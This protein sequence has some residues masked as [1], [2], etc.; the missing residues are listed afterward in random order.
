MIENLNEQAVK[1]I[2]NRYGCNGLYP[3]AYS[4]DC[5]FCDGKNNAYDCCE[6][7]ADDFYEGYIQALLD[8]DEDE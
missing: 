3:C 8:Q 5:Q 4:Y 6:C 2:H 1:A 7:G